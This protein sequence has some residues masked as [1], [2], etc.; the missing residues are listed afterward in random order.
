ML[1][2]WWIHDALQ[3]WNRKTL[4]LVVKCVATIGL[5]RV[6]AC[7]CACGRSVC[8]H[9]VREN[10]ENLTEA[11]PP[12]LSGIS[13]DLGSSL[14]P[15]VYGCHGDDVNLRH[16]FSPVDGFGGGATKPRRSTAGAIIILSISAHSHLLLDR[17]RTHRSKMREIVHL[18]AG[19]C[20]NQIGAKVIH[21]FAFS[22]LLLRSGEAASIHA[23]TPP[24]R[25]E[26]TSNPSSR[27]YLCLN[28]SPSHQETLIKFAYLYF[29]QSICSDLCNEQ[30]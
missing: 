28:K 12:I 25:W 4:T 26:E 8:V 11:P 24:W 7:A 30:K 23:W 16:R 13:T 14:S 3:C 29:L 1:W 17:P 20:G 27:I 18:Q 15:P 6:C 19:Q 10:N 22:F 21:S 5:H 9:S 2:T